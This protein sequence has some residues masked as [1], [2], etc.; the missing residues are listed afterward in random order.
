MTQT[1]EGS[2]GADDDED[3]GY[4]S[5]SDESEEAVPE[6]FRIETAIGK[7]DC[8]LFFKQTLT[9]TLSAICKSLILK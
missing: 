8:Y 6:E 4:E 3:G 5:Y 2:I 7:I 1:V 9:G